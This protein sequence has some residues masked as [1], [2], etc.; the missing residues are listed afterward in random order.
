MRSQPGSIPLCRK[1]QDLFLRHQLTA[2][3]P[4]NISFTENK[5]GGGGRF[6][7]RSNDLLSVL[8]A[9]DLKQIAGHVGPSYGT[10]PTPTPQLRPMHRG[11]CHLQFCSPL[12]SFKDNPTP[13][14]RHLTL[15]SAPFQARPIEVGSLAGW[16]ESRFFVPF[17]V[18][19]V[20]GRWQPV[21][22][23]AFSS[24]NYIG[25]WKTRDRRKFS[26]N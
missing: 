18:P 11:R 21:W 26:P 8:T 23:E 16:R 4:V 10:S 9:G 2:S 20:P 5:R 22:R 13:T 15:V 6:L 24:R 14:P 12:H 17:L 25:W 3:R 19:Q 1:N 7:G